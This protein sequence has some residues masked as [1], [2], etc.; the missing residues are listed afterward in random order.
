MMTSRANALFASLFLL[1]SHNI[2]AQE[3]GSNAPQI[4]GSSTV[5]TV[6][7]TTFRK[8]TPQFFGFNLELIE[9]ENSLWNKRD[10][11]VEASVVRYLQ[12][13]P[14]AAYRYPGGATANFFDWKAATGPV[15][16]RSPQQLVDWQPARAVQFGPAEYL[17][18]VR[19]VRGTPWYVLNLYGSF[20]S[21]QP[22]QA[23]TKSAADLARFMGSQR[24]KGSPSIF[25]W[26][27]GSELDRGSFR[28]PA[29]TYASAA[30]VIAASVRADGGATEFVAMAQDWPHT[31][32][33]TPGVNY[34]ATV[35]QEL[36]LETTEFA[37]HLYYDGAPW[38]PP[39]PRVVRQFCKNLGSIKG[40]APRDTMWVTEHGRTPI[41]TPDDL[42]WKS[43]WPQTG[44]LAAAISSADMMITLA[45]TNDV[46]GAFVHAL[47]GAGPWPIF[48][49][50]SDGAIYPS[51]VYWAMVL[52]R[53]TLMDD[54]LNATV[55]TT[56]HGADSAGYD[57]NAAVLADLSRSRIT[58][59][60]VNR[61]AHESLALIRIP[62]LAG[63]RIGIKIGTLTSKDPADGNYVEP[64]K[65]F[66]MR[67]EVLLEVD[68]NGAFPL[69]LPAHSVTTLNI[70]LASEG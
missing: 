61:S 16:S 60:L 68:A 41:G 44:S 53:E 10:H 35:A 40:V 4:G 26:E 5:I 15:S 14:G 22:I 38:G 43:N 25:R 11:R 3:C 59:W 9:F 45:R 58:A 54:V 67:R 2:H 27:L 69:P 51:A 1:L 17:D 50:R 13:F 8:I 55:S 29:S 57:T 64:Y 19:E 70:E 23:M 34:N 18:F 42:A 56:N 47:H 66:P 65:V 62:L 49:K 52:L 31:G 6:Q 63:R 7:S 30:K 48:H 28:W 21:Q 32:A 46:N 20:Q 24:S 12:R 37:A 33:S 39:L 36:A